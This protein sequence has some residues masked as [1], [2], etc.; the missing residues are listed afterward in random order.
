VIVTY[1]DQ[2][3]GEEKTRKRRSWRRRGDDEQALDV[4]LDDLKAATAKVSVLVK[5]GLSKKLGKKNNRTVNVKSGDSVVTS[6]EV[7]QG[8]DQPF[9]IND[10][11]V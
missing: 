2:D 3:G 11:N 10:I 7:P 9:E 6:K 8:M 5:E 1:Y 4:S